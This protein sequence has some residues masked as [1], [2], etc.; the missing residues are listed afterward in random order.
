VAWVAWTI[1]A[2]AQ[3]EIDKGP[4]VILGLFLVCILDVIVREARGQSP[5][6]QTIVCRT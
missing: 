6:A 3:F 1:K 4:E 2:Y 5:F